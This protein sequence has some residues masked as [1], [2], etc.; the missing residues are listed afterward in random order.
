M[1]KKIWKAD[2]AGLFNG[3]EERCVTSDDPY[4]GCEGDYPFHGP[5]G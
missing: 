2:A 4:N 1:S 3:G 5:L